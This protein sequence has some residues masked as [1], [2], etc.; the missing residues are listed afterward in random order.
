M[1]TDPTNRVV[2]SPNASDITVEIYGG[3]RGVI[4]T[5][6]GHEYYFSAQEAFDAQQQIAAVLPRL[7][8]AFR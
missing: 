4:V 2:S 1:T 3:G 7:H 5:I 6:N 8:Q